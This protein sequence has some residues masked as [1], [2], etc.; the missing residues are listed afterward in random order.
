M[1]INAPTMYKNPH[2]KI[3]NELKEMFKECP[4]PSKDN[5]KLQKVF[6]SLSTGKTRAKTFVG[7]AQTLEKAFEHVCQK[8]EAAYV[9]IGL[10]KYIL[11][12]IVDQEEKMSLENFYQKLK[13]TRRGYLRYGVSFDENY[14]VAFLEQEV[15]GA[16][17]IKYINRRTQYFNQENVNRH[18]KYNVQRDLDLD[19]EAVKEIILFTT[20][21]V[22]YENGKKEILENNVQ[23]LNYH[24]RKYPDKVSE[25]FLLT[26]LEE[27]GDFL[28]STIQSNGRFIYGYFPCF[29]KE[30]AG[31]NVMRAAIGTF[32]L[33][34]L[35][36]IVPKDL[37]KEKAI[38]S[39]EY[40][41]ENYVVEVED[42]AF[43]K[44]EAE[45]DGVSELKCGAIGMAILAINRV[46]E[47]TD[48]QEHSLSWKF[49]LQKLARGILYMQNPDGSFNH[50]LNS[51]DL[52]I[53]NKFRTVFYDGEAVF[54]LSKVYSLEQ[55]DAL[56]I[57]IRKALGYFIQNQYEQHSD[58]WQAYAVNEVSKHLT[59]EEYFKFG[60]RNLYHDL[61]FIIKRDTTWN[62]FLEMLN[63]SWFLIQKIQRSGQEGLL[64]PYNLNAFHKAIQTRLHVQLS[65]IM[66]PELAMFY[67]N[68]DLIKKGVF[69]RHHQQR[70]RNDD[71][72]HHLLGFCN[73]YRNV[74]P[75]NSKNKSI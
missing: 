73:Y 10:P 23:S 40:M 14:E 2:A 70:V 67:K 62:T 71:V 50:V 75:K 34:D 33:A 69:I 36:E 3:S 56:L 49:L 9:Q 18:F 53:K 41:I 58:H 16:S 59:V 74:F 7:I 8:V 64:F 48:E 72:A 46:M 29:A 12:S 25:G 35:Y 39:L 44:E 13:N 26:G 21:S 45:T 54:G 19:M 5:K 22:F 17:L 68:P 57:A 66:Q 43:I 11:F 4:K 32:S 55:D 37:Y 1:K 38:L 65:S 6:I 20:C 31:Y 42:M 63:A 52:S 30:C 61:D 51:N 60:L 27:T 24:L 47:I 28:A 15:Y